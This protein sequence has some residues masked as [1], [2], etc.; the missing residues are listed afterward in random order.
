MWCSS[1]CVC[2]MLKQNNTA[3]SNE[4]LVEF[5]LAEMTFTFSKKN[6]Q[7]NVIPQASNHFILSKY[8]SLLW[9]ISFTST[10]METASLSGH[11]LLLCDSSETRP[12]R[13]AV[14]ITNDVKGI[15]H[16]GEVYLHFM[17]WLI[18]CETTFNHGLYSETAKCYL[19]KWKLNEWISHWFLLY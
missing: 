4:T 15:C 9:K 7:Q 19:G 14:S 1:S 12:G 10:W 3:E 6:A 11:L 13:L 2:H 5:P 17:T 18:A 16:S 8:C